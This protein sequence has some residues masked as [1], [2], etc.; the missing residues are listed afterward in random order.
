[1]HITLSFL[2]DTMNIFEEDPS[3][4]CF[5]IGCKRIKNSSCHFLKANQI[6]KIQLQL[7]VIDFD[8]IFRVNTNNAHWKSL[9][10]FVYPDPDNTVTIPIISNV[11]MFLE[12]DTTLFTI[13]GT[14]LQMA[15]TILDDEE[16]YYSDDCD[17]HDDGNDGHNGD[18]CDDGDD[19]DEYVDE[20]QTNIGYERKQDY[21]EES[22]K[23]KAFSDESEETQE[24]K[25]ISKGT[26]ESKNSVSSEKNTLENKENSN[27]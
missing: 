20:E 8:I 2:S 25:E 7:D 18:K 12:P 17:D 5:H 11:D 4:H 14:T 21:E 22:K 15:W 27:E 13:C 24:N 1:M 23:R 6:T 9:Y 3:F 16:I 10:R 26:D 19:G